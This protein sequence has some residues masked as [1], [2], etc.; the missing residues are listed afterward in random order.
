MVQ[1]FIINN[2]NK[3]NNYETAFLKIITKERKK[4]DFFLM[5]IEELAGTFCY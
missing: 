4:I 5:V 3:K 2:N 1:A